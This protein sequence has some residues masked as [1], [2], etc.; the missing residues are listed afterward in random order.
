MPTRQL[1]CGQCGSIHVRPHC[2]SPT[3]L[4]VFCTSC[5][6]ITGIVGGLPHAIPGKG[7]A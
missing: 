2:Q 5:R 7:A 1:V 3:C 4:W 6:F